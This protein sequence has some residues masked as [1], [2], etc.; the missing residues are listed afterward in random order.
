LRLF[1]FTVGGASVL[2][3]PVRRL[4]R[5]QI[6]AK[7]R[8]ESSMSAASVAP[9]PLCWREGDGRYCRAND[10]LLPAKRRAHHSR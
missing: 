5:V 9:T 2:M 7:Q 4:D 3:T 10:A 1:A 6:N 8:G